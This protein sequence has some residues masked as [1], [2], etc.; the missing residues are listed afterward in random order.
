MIFPLQL[1]KENLMRESGVCFLLA[2]FFLSVPLRPLTRP[3]PQ[4]LHSWALSEAGFV[5]S[6]YTHLMRLLLSVFRG[7]QTLH[8]ISFGIHPTWA[9]LQA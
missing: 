7:F 8:Y 2:A 1:G 5:V 6:V 3:H 4:S 9:V